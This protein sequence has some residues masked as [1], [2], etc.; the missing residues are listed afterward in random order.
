M[1]SRATVLALAVGVTGLGLASAATPQCTSPEVVVCLDF[2]GHQ[3]PENIVQEP[4]GSFDVTFSLAQ[5]VARIGSDGQVKVLADMTEK[6]S[7][8]SR[9]PLLHVPVTMGLTRA[10]D[11]TLYF[12]YADAEPVPGGTADR[13]GVY[14]LRP[15]AAEPELVA[16]LPAESLPNGLALDGR[17]GALYFSDSA[18]GRV[19]TVP[20]AGGEPAVFA[21]DGTLKADGFAANGLKLRDGAV[22]V[23]N[24]VQGTIVRIPVLGG[25]RGGH[26]QVRAT[27]L[28]TVDDFAFTGHG[29]E[30]LAALAG[31][32]EVVLVH[33][34]GHPDGSSTVVRRGDG[35]QTPTSPV[36]SGGTAYVASAAYYT[37]AGPDI[38]PVA[39][40]AK[41]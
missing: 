20:A 7:T 34:Q 40:D 3:T 39:L 13:T 21:D 28:P 19:W 10:E 17:S 22:W 8:G 32:D 6:G 18:L 12:L 4:D 23:S 14:R 29:D 11:G 5:Q 25:N 1:V 33:P 24:S 27:G 31:R 36:I 15:D 26:P 9:T 16:R 35:L 30:L 41:R 37:K 38:L 2:A